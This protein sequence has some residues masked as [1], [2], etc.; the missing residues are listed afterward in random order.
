MVLK[1]IGKGLMWEANKPK[2]LMIKPHKD[3]LTRSLA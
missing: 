2:V 3:G 1:H